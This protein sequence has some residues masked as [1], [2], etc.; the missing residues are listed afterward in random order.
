[1]KKPVPPKPSKTKMRMGAPV[2]K[3]ARGG[4]MGGSATG[5]G[6][7]M[8]RPNSGTGR[9]LGNVSVSKPGNATA[10]PLPSPGAAMPMP[11]ARPPGAVSLPAGGRTAMRKG[12]VVSKAAG[13]GM[14]GNDFSG[15]MRIGRV[16]FNGGGKYGSG[17]KDYGGRPTFSPS[18]DMNV[19]N[20]LKRRKAKNEEPTTGGDDPAYRKGGMVKKSK[21]KC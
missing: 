14:M 18:F 5:V 10:R 13:G 6:G 8:G 12:G 4:V 9:G 19:K 21:G 16:P 15:A 3:A 20:N 1:M 2:A 17:L 11:R 7:S